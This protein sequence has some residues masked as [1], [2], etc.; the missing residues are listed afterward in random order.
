MQ[1]EAIQR[2]QLAEGA[3]GIPLQVRVLLR[4]LEAGVNFLSQ[5]APRK[6]TITLLLAILRITELIEDRQVIN[7]II[8]H[9]RAG[10]RYGGDF[11]A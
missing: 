5:H 3:V 2:G 11:L 10:C 1:D 9:G 8:V 6:I 7:A 4:F